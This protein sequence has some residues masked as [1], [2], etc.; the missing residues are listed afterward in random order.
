MYIK[1]LELRDFRNYKELHLPISDGINIFYGDNAQGKTNILEAVY[2]G[3]TTKSHKGSKDKDIIRLGCE[4]SHIRIGFFKA[5]T[6]YTI[7]MHLRKGKSKGIAI[8]RIPIR[9]S[10]ELI[11]LM[12][13]IFFSP[14]DLSIIKNGP[15]E[16]RRFLDMELCQ[17]D[18][19]YL[20]HLSMYNKILGQRN[21]LLKQM[22]KKREE[23]ID[24]VE[25]WD[26]Q[27]IAHGKSLIEERRRFVDEMN[28]I[29]GKTH[30][31]LTGG[32]EDVML[33]YAPA[34]LEGDFQSRLRDNLERDV[35]LKSTSIGPHRDDLIFFEG[36]KDLRKYGSQGQQRTVA[37]SLKLSEIELMKKK[38][39]D[40]PI[41]LLDDV[42]SELDRSRQQY[43]LESLRDVQTLITCTGLEEFV[44][45]QI[46]ARKVY[47]VTQGSVEEIGMLS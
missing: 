18:K 2:I 17:I 20:Y 21:H 28:E 43:L 30:N 41:L 23:L 14:E 10:G 16:R 29:F 1:S 33:R 27:L 8:D 22:G 25:V 38:T 11:G 6:D 44:L 34:V 4:E 9:R 35:I 31:R 45:K 36:E 39:G 37:L 19:I 24:T 13:V 40:H 3:G 15:G 47:K 26:E 46:E 42:F 7:D 5:D 12:P 32:K